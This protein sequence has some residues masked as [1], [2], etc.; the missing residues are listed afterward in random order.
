MTLAEHEWGDPT[1]L[2]NTVAGLTAYAR[3][4]PHTDAR[5]DFERKAGALLDLA[6][7]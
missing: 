5:V 6:V 7:K 2:F 4:I 1:N 3:T